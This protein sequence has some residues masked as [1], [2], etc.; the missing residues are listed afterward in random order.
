METWRHLYESD[1]LFK[2][3]QWHDSFVFDKIRKV[4]EKTNLIENINL[5]PWGKDYDHVFINSILGDYM[6]HL[7]GPRKNYGK[8]YSSD[9][10]NVKNHEYWT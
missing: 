6:D 9:L 10:F 5:S 3:E 4:Y 7:K 1:E 8:S 2:L